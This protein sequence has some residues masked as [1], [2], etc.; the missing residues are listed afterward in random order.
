MGKAEMPQAPM[1]GLMA[2]RESQQSQFPK[3]Q[4]RRRVHDKGKQPQDQDQQRL[5]LEASH[6]AVEK[7]VRR[8]GG[9]D[10]QAQEERGDIRDLVAVRPGSGAPPR[11]ASWSRLPSIR[12][13]MSGAAAGASRLMKIVTAMR[14]DEHR[15]PRNR[16]WRI[17]HAYAPLFL[18]R[19]QAHERRLDDRNQAH[20][21]VG[22]HGDGTEQ[23]GR[24]LGRLT[25]IAVGPSIA[26]I[27]PIDAASG[28]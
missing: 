2:P 12:L 13:A 18:R 1:S 19:Q 22:G 11:P 5:P 9:A 28:S 4:P 24:Q 6:W 23:F 20:V 21:G 17:D 7:A 16:A 26:P 27:T 8:H 25:K 3:E 15:P 10:G 14:E